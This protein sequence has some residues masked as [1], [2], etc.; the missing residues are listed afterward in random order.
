MFRNTRLRN[1][2]CLFDYVAVWRL[3]TLLNFHTKLVVFSVV[4]HLNAANFTF[5]LVIFR[6]QARML[7][8]EAIMQ[9]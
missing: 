1:I 2:N 5:S 4:D 8:N 9:Q 6:K 7:T 3:N